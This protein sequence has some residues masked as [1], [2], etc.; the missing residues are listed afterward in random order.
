MARPQVRARP[1]GEEGLEGRRRGEGQGLVIPKVLAFSRGVF[2]RNSHGLPPGQRTPAPSCRAGRRELE[3]P[4]R[5]CAGAARAPPASE[6]RPF[7]LAE[8]G[9]SARRVTRVEIVP[10]RSQSCSSRK[11][12]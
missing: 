5:P 3:F 8:K 6:R 9:K 7:P 11:P 2:R 4:P 10:V 1:G 12:H